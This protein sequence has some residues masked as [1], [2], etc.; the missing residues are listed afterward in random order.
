M[1][2]LLLILC[3][4]SFSIIYSQEKE[5][6]KEKSLSDKKNEVK[7]GG[8]KLLAGPI[9]EGTYEYIYSKDFTFGSSILVNLQRDNGYPEDFSVTPFARFYFQ[10]SKEY[11]AQGFFVEG[12]AK[13][14]SGKYAKIYP[15]TENDRKKFSAPA[16]G[17]S[18]GKKWVNNSGF[19]FEILVGV[20]RT[21]GNSTVAPDAVF[22]GDLNIGY[23]F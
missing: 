21:L 23:R 22:R 1:K 13:Y 17:L 12:F 20:G 3:L 10:E 9:L 19:V 5:I 14:Y 11:G 8:I 16:L 18:L 7:V 6:P 4:S 2:K 15:Y